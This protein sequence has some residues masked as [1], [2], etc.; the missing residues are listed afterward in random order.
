MPDAM[1]IH[2]GVN[3]YD[4]P[5]YVPRPSTLHCAEHDARALADLAQAQG[6]TAH[7]AIG[8]EVTRARVLALFERAEALAS[9]DLL[10]LTFSGHGAR[11]RD[12]APALA[13]A[14]PASA[15]NLKI[16]DEAD[17]IDE[18]WCLYDGFLLDDELNQR[19]A[20][21]AAGVR[22]F[23]ISDS[24]HSGT[25]LRLDD[26][27]PGRRFYRRRDARASFAANLDI[28]QQ[29]LDDAAAA[30]RD[31]TASVIHFAAC[32]DEGYAYEADGHGL[33]TGAVID[34]WDGGAFTGSHREL[35]DA[36][37][38]RTQPRQQPAL[39]TIGPRD[40][41]FTAGRPFTP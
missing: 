21:L 18:V 1:S 3:I 8:A 36:I 6:I 15:R 17:G 13:A 14:R 11:L 26:I 2:L 22:V 19:L 31:V 39:T 4:H 5:L 37:A 34:V 10:V 40:D 16:G 29:L 30:A 33:L 25:M 38:G 23:A 7:V 27:L 35:F 24:C 9:G 28:Y 12:L 20:R 32:A 41:A